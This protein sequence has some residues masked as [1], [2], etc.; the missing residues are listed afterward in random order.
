MGEVS[1][2]L[3]AAAMVPRA[4]LVEGKSRGHVG[5]ATAGGEHADQQT[6][7]GLVLICLQALTDERLCTSFGT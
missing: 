3:L 1:L 4:R 5:H 2:N 7:N 6:H